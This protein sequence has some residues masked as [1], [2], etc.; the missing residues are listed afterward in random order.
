MKG[1]RPRGA[2][3]G[4][5]ALGL[6]ACTSVPAG[7]TN[8]QVEIIDWWTAGGEKDAISAL[9]DQ[10]QL[11]YPNETPLPMP[12]DGSDVARTTIDT[13]MNGNQPPDTFQANG[14]WDL[15]TWV[16]L[17]DVDDRSSKMEPINQFAADL[18]RTMP[19]AV[20]KTVSF[21]N[22]S[23]TNTYGI[24]LDIHR[25]NTL[26]YNT[27]LLPSFERSP[28]TSLDDL[29]AVAA[30]LQAKGL[31]TP[32]SLGAADSTL[33][34]LF[35]EN[36]LVSRAGAKFYQ[37]FMLG[38]GDAYAPEIATAVDDLATLLTYANANAT[39]LNWKDAAGRVVSGDAAMTIMGDWDKAYMVK[40]LLATAYVPGGDA[41]VSATDA[42]TSV[43][44]GAIPTPGTLGTFVFTTD[45]FG[46]PRGAPNRTGTLD[47]LTLFASAAGQDIF[48][49]IKGSISPRSDTDQSLYDDMGRQTIS[50]FNTATEVVAAT[51]ILAP[52]EFVDAINDALV[53]FLKD[54]N[55]SAVIHAIAN[56]YDM[57]QNGPLSPL[58]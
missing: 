33:P 17:N 30:Q 49:P 38:V 1:T 52:P 32:I 27:A 39:Q 44:F 53:Q 36:L 47:L 13:L 15:L 14:G 50:D 34:I 48:N 19:P 35:F 4:L 11:Q 42:G 37:D 51:A 20:L 22:S 25:T 54:G 21:T 6:A 9:L 18:T 31:A 5:A 56:R 12:F 55:K 10:F 43:L 46:L 24:P 45:T 26:F 41:G 29:F 23:A 28:P 40:T 7:R 2:R 58:L 3:A 16:V 8:S 57:L